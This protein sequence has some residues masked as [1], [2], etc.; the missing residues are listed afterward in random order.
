MLTP[1]SEEALTLAE[2]RF[3][4]RFF[5]SLTRAAR[6]MVAFVAVVVALSSCDNLTGGG[7]EGTLRIHFVRGQFAT[8]AVTELPDTN[9]FRL[10]IMDGGGKAIFDGKFGD[11]PEKMIVEAG[12]YTISVRSAEFEKPE[13]SAPVYGDDQC[14]VVP[15]GGV[16]SVD[17]L[18]TQ[19][20]SGVRLKIEPNFL[21]SFPKGTLF[22]R[23][24]EGRLMYS[25][26]EKRIAYFRP[27]EVSLM[28]D[29]DGVQTD[30]LTRSLEPK[31]IL[32]VGIS[33]PEPSSTEGGV[34][35]IRISIDTTRIWTGAD[36]TIGGDTGR[37]DEIDAA[38][39]VMTARK[40]T[41]T[42]GVWVYGYIV[43]SFKSTNHIQF[44]SPYPTATNLAISGKTS[45]TDNGSCLSIELKKGEMRDVL[46]LVDNPDN[47]GRKVFFKGD[48]VEAYY[49]IP[50]VKNVTDYV[51]K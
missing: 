15:A 44:E 4:D 22:L 24:S 20:N 48:I 30:L 43:G 28:M 13:F 50:G 31:E 16:E 12:T 18:C 14:V 9:D 45:T 1:F 41:G 35:Q 47:R 19:V 26:S 5:V 51:V 34:G 21:T 32:T 39:D 29:D 8:K 46:N 11:V 25:Y 27:G 6:V 23:S 7:K 2:K 3:M 49:G 37:G 10:R 33:A 36:V 17:I 42:K 38:M 40:S